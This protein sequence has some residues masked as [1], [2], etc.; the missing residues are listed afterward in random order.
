MSLND[1]LSSQ[2]EVDSDEDSQ[3]EEYSLKRNYVFTTGFES[4]LLSIGLLYSV[5]N[6]KA[7]IRPKDCFYCFDVPI[8]NAYNESCKE[9]HCN[10]N[11]FNLS[12]YYELHKTL[13]IFFWVPW[14][15]NYM[16]F[17]MPYEFLIDRTIVHINRF[18]R[19]KKSTV[20]YYVDRKILLAPTLAKKTG[21]QFLTRDNQEKIQ[22]VFDGLIN[23]N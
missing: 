20:T 6:R 11:L 13:P 9:F 7:Q 10:I 17:G 2:Y 21:E 15:G 19:S 8:L 3:E 12:K 18:L 1:Q 16:P 22:K 23:E 14:V 4:T 5:K